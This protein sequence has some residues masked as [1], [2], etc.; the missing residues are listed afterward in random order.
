MSLRKHFHPP[1]LGGEEATLHK[2]GCGT[3]FHSLVLACLDHASTQE[4][5]KSAIGVSSPLEDCRIPAVP[6]P[7]VGYGGYQPPESPLL[8]HP[9]FPDKGC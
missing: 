7:I 6:F 9:Y 2:F 4:Y 3:G 1:C 5:H 8:L